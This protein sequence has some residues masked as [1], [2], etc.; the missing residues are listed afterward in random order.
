V[1]LYEPLFRGPKTAAQVMAVVKG[2]EGFGPWAA[3]KAADILERL[4]LVK[5]KFD[6]ATAMY[7]SPREG[8]MQ[9]WRDEGEPALSGKS[10]GEWA[11]GQ[12]LEKLGRYMAPPRYE[13]TIGLQEV[14]TILC[15]NLS[16][17]HG[18]YKVGEDIDACQKALERFKDCALATQLM[19]AGVRGKLW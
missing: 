15:K 18:R 4:G 11:V 3:F 12:L 14:E 9:Y 8:A 7:E 19:A 13:R 1:G 17:L 16:Y 2:W 6:L 5:I 10:V